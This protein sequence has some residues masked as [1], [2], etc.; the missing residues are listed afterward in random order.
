MA[1]Q[2]ARKHLPAMYDQ[3]RVEFER[4]HSLKMPHNE[5]VEA[6]LDMGLTKSGLA[7][8]AAEVYLDVLMAAV[9]TWISTR[10]TGGARSVC[11]ARMCTGVRR[12]L[13]EVSHG[14]TAV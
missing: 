7:R 9:P 5:C 12:R 10:G 2:E 13:E 3:L 4:R 11:I 8:D 1:L 6:I 14:Y